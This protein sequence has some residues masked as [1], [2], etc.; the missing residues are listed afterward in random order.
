MATKEYFNLYWQ[1]NKEKIK[2]QRREY[3]KTEEYKKLRHEQNRRYYL[4]K[5]ELKYK[6]LTEKIPD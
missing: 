6:E 3:A 5:K 1:Q 4:K 2:L